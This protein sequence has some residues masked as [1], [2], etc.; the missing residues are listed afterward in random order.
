MRGNPLALVIDP[1]STHWRSRLLWAMVVERGEDEAIDSGDNQDLTDEG[2]HLGGCGK[3]AIVLGRWVVADR[4]LIY[5]GQYE[6]RYMYL[7]G[8]N[9][10]EG[11][12]K[13]Q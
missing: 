12:F 9:Q 1:N 11:A 6:S 10:T 2:G 5:T 4:V 8:G 3:E 7:C 13:S